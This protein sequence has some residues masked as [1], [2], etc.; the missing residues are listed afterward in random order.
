MFEWSIQ[1][2]ISWFKNHKFTQICS[3]GIICLYFLSVFRSVPFPV[4]SNTPFFSGHQCGSRWSLHIST[5]DVFYIILSD[6]VTYFNV[7]SNNSSTLHP[8]YKHS[9]RYGHRIVFMIID[10]VI[11]F[12]GFSDYYFS[13]LMTREVIDCPIMLEH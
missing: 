1:F 12:K 8:Y 5:F 11:N 10:M 13:D 6:T 7:L 2:R 4:F 9:Y 3:H